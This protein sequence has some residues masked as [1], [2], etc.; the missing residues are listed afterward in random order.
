MKKPNA[1]RPNPAT[2]AKELLATHKTIDAAAPPLAELIGTNADLRLAFAFDYLKRIAPAPQASRRRQGPHKVPRRSSK[3]P[4]AIQ[5]AGALRAERQ[6]THQIFARKL[7]GGR[8]L[9]DVRV[10]ELRAIAESSAATATSF[11]TRGYDDAVESIACVMLANHCV[12]ADPFALVKDT[13]K[14]TTVVSIFERAQVKAAEAIRDS[15]AKMASD[16]LAIGKTQDLAI[17]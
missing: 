13:I 11:L 15:S 7:R 3:S 6:F 12:S 1:K 16:L 14:T 10:H 2:T 9:G 4:T 8:T 5:K 17:Q